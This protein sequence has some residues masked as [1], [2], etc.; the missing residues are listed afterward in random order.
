MGLLQIIRCGA[1]ETLAVANGYL[2]S[3]M[4]W[5]V[6]FHVMFRWNEYIRLDRMGECVAAEK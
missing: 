5:I 6:I 1:D 4:A 2:I 3:V